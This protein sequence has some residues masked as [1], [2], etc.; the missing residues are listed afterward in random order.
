[1]LLPL[2]ILL[3]SLLLLLLDVLLFFLL[4]LPLDVLLLSL[5]LLLLDVLLLFLLL[6]PLGILLLSLL[7]LLPLNV[8][9]LFLL[10]LSCGHRRLNPLN[11]TH[12]DNANGLARS[13]H[14]LAYGSNLGR[15]KRPPG[16]LHQ[17]GLL[18]VKWHRGRRRRGARHYGAAQD[19]GW[20]TH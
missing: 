2:G 15:S 12:I 6:L 5:L 8:L 20:R 7:L 1:M 19:V 17:S 9:L 14:P 11:T 13:R 4:F 3:L 16:V 18:E 10:L